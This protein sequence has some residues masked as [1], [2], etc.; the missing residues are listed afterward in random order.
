M[1][2][3]GSEGISSVSARSDDNT[4]FCKSKDNLKINPIEPKLS[5][6][7]RDKVID[8]IQE[9]PEQPVRKKKTSQKKTKLKESEDNNERYYKNFDFFYLRSLFRDMTKFYKIKFE[10]FYEKKLVALKKTDFA[11]W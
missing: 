5:Q 6:P 11:S 4:I 1:Q 7:A 8:K 9:N 3:Q 10:K 2:Q